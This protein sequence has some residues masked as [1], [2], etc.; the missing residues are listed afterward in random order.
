SQQ[1]FSK[2]VQAL[3]NTFTK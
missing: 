3:Y 1:D 2:A